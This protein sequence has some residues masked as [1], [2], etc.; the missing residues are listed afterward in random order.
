LIVNPKYYNLLTLERGKCIF[1]TGMEGDVF[2]DAKIRKITVV[3]YK[4]EVE[5]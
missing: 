2:L 1:L 5:I 4:R 3:S